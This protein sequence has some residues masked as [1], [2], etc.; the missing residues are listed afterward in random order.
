MRCHGSIRL[1]LSGTLNS[2]HLPAAMEQF[3]WLLSIW[4]PIYT[5]PA[6][7][8]QEAVAKCRN[9]LIRTAIKGIF[10]KSLVRPRIERISALRFL[11]FGFLLSVLGKSAKVQCLGGW[12]GHGIQPKVTI[13]YVHGPLADTIKRFKGN[14]SQIDNFKIVVEDGTALF[15]GG[16]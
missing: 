13:D 12:T 14:N 5:K 1:P 7:R 4:S 8:M 11:A 10:A 16:T 15:V 6:L 9:T 2:L 3:A